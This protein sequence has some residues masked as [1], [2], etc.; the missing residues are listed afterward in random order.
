MREALHTAL[1]LVLFLGLNLGGSALALE[2]W[3]QSLSLARPQKLSQAPDFTTPGLDGSTVRMKDHSGGVIFLNFWAT[4]CPPCVEEMPSMERL[5]KRLQKKG[6]TVIALSID[7]E[8]ERVVKPFVTE[9]RLTYPIGLDPK[10]TVAGDYRVRGLPSSFI[11]DRKG[12]VVATAFGPREWDRPEAVDFFESLLDG[13]IGRSTMP[14]VQVTVL[15]AF[16]A[17]LLS[18]LSP[19]VLPLI[20]SYLSFITGMSLNELTGHAERNRRLVILHSTAF[21]AGFSIVFIALGVSFS[22]LGRLL[23]DFRDVIQ[24]VGGLLIIVFGLYLTGILRL[25]WFSR[26]AQLQLATKPAG[27]LGSTLVGITF[28]AAWTPCFGPILG[29]ILALAGT[30]GTMETGVSLLFAYSMGLALPF[31]GSSLAV[32]RFL[33]GYRRFRRFVPVFEWTAGLLLVVVGVLVAT[34]YMSVLNNYLI[35]LTPL[36]LFNRL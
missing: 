30:T 25:S 33:R 28:A 19:C 2:H 20:P 10:M 24:V 27:Y 17:G 31:F 32:D 11:I 6:L 26:V 3:N 7:I 21:I 34:N 22:A 23:F 12:Q 8:G 5:Y 13:E 1:M 4:W 18:F 36:W 35:G 15:I 29:S 16:L 9:L 14:G